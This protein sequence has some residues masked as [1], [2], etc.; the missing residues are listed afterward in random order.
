VIAA[1]ASGIGNSR[2]TGVRSSTKLVHGA[3]AAAQGSNQHGEAIIVGG[4]DRG[5]L[6]GLGEH[7]AGMQRVRSEKFARQRC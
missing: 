3:L 4:R 5:D 7:C 6:F 1:R 2:A